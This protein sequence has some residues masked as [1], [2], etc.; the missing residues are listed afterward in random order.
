AE[1]G[2]WKMMLRNNYETF[3]QAAQLLNEM[4]RH[5]EYLKHDHSDTL[6]NKKRQKKKLIMDKL[7]LQSQRKDLE[8]GDQENFPELQNL[9]QE[10]RQ[11]IENLNLLYKNVRGI[12]DNGVQYYSFF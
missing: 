9:M 5:L 8:E 3:C 12:L 10:E 4:Q 7:Q 11:K 6:F 2:R 1:K